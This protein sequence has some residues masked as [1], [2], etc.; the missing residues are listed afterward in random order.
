MTL[1]NKYLNKLNQSIISIVMMALSF[2]VIIRTYMLISEMAQAA[3]NHVEGMSLLLS[4]TS[5]A[6]TIVYLIMF[7]GVVALVQAIG[8]AIQYLHNHE[9]DACHIIYFISSAT[10]VYTAFKVYSL[11]S[12][13]SGIL[14]QGI[15]DVEDLLGSSGDWTQMLGLIPDAISAYTD[16]FSIV[17]IVVYSLIGAILTGFYGSKLIRDLMKHP[18]GQVSRTYIPGSVS[19]NCNEASTTNNRQTAQPEV[20]RAKVPSISITDKIKG[21]SRKQKTT[22]ISVTAV[23]VLALAG[24][25]V[26]DVFFNFDKIDLV[27]NMTQPTFS[28]Y[29][30]EGIVAT[31]P[32]VGNLDYDR[33]KP[34]I[35]EFVNSI[36]YKLDKKEGLSNG[37]KV[38]V[39]AQYSAETAK[40]L[41]IKVVNDSTTVKVSGLIGRFKNGK[42]IEKKDLKVIEAAMEAEA[43]SA[44]E[45]HYDYRDESHT[46]KRLALLFARDER[47]E[48]NSEGCNDKLLGI[49]Q[50][51]CGED[52]E[53]FIVE[54]YGSIDSQ[55]DFKN[56]EYSA[57]YF[58][59]HFTYALE[60]Y[61]ED[62][63]AYTLT[64]IGASD[65]K[66]KSIEAWY[67]DNFAAISMVVYPATIHPSL[68][69]DYWEV[70][71]KGNTITYEYTFNEK[72]GKSEQK[73]KE[74]E[75]DEAMEDEVSTFGTIA[76]M[77]EQKSGIKGVTLTV[78]YIDKKNTV[79]YSRD[80]TKKDK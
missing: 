16:I 60:P 52:T 44:A 80:F 47:E 19:S 37:D 20:Q 54:T 41:K 53:Y 79:L 55:T 67:S 31:G 1:I 71:V 76:G 12:K 49:Y 45:N 23:I 25:K 62:E 10:L 32:D 50:T 70:V 64:D 17:G 11:G 68:R 9:R 63:S 7:L 24:F 69:A 61:L 28:G 66:Y 13:F 74:K 29:D 27:E 3:E 73:D 35:E 78:R 40:S 43:E 5:G 75:I 15:G 72:Y 8:C 2:F 22:I 38:T 39:I 42:D 26:Y 18:G 59:D 21:L 56:V 33:T 34:G 48:F 58:D 51:V 65:K 77:L 30:G 4:V 57:S 14:N 6:K 46:C 36:T